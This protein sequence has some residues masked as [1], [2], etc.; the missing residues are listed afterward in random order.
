MS[1]VTLSTLILLCVLRELYPHSPAGSRSLGILLFE[2]GQHCLLLRAGCYK[3]S[4]NL[5]IIFLP[6]QRWS[7]HP[8]QGKNP[9]PAILQGLEIVEPDRSPTFNSPVHSTFPPVYFFQPIGN[10]QLNREVAGPAMN[11]FDHNHHILPEGSKQFSWF[12]QPNSS[13]ELFWI[14][15]NLSSWMFVNHFDP[16]P[17][18][19]YLAQISL[20]FGSRYLSPNDAIKP[21]SSIGRS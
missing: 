8:L 2:R 14:S 10:Q 1:K 16:Q 13:R 3:H 17:V 11:Q 6:Q 19:L 5:R 7:S 12:R 15:S 9:F 18:I 4:L 21:N 20:S